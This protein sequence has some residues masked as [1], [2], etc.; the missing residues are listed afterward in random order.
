MLPPSAEDMS[1]PCCHIF[2]RLT[3][4]AAGHSCRSIQ[5]FAKLRT[6]W[7]L[8]AHAR[9]LCGTMRHPG[10]TY[11]TM[12]QKLTLPHKEHHGN[13]LPMMWR[14]SRASSCAGRSHGIFCE[15][16]FGRQFMVNLTVGEACVAQSHTNPACV[17]THF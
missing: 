7:K 9:E 5:L 4:V 2:M 3:S 6:H 11:G 8:S 1:I 12:H 10:V 16:A 14:A 17:N 15:A 13:C